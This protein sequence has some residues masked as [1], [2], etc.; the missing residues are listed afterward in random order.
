MFPAAPLT[1]LTL[2]H[3][4][5]R[6]ILP[7]HEFSQGT[8][9]GN[10]NVIQRRT[11]GLPSPFSFIPSSSF[12][13]PIL[14]L[15]PPVLSPL[16]S[17]FL[18]YLNSFFSSSFSLPV[19]LLSPSMLSSPLSLFLTC[20][21]SY[22]IFDFLFYSCISSFPFFHYVLFS[23]HSSFFFSVAFFFVILLHCHHFPPSLFLTGLLPFLFPSTSFPIDGALFFIPCLSVP[24]LCPPPCPL[25]QSSN[26]ISL[27]MG[28]LSCFSCPSPVLRIILPPPPAI[29][30]LPFSLSLYPCSPPSGLGVIKVEMSPMIAC[31]VILK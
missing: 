31:Y 20:L 4:A 19:L 3:L 16:S 13:I 7:G 12:T 10:R 2:S 6:V 29:R 25:S 23:S 1:W 14:L 9:A 27:S 21:Y 26:H 11:R 28:S 15:S 8:F 18:T 17:L 22:F 5:C 24:F 30:S